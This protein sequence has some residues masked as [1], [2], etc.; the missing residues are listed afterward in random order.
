MTED[1][2]NYSSNPSVDVSA[3]MDPRPNDGAKNAVET[4][5]E[6]LAEVMSDRS[7]PP[8]AR[9]QAATYILGMASQR[10][11]M[12]QFQRVQREKEESGVRPE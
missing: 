9:V 8:E 12:E 5:E 11:H 6:V 1:T 2:P 7:A 4:A 3:E 10:A